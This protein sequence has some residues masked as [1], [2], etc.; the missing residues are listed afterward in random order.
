MK[1]TNNESSELTP[2]TGISVQRNVIMGLGAWPLLMIVMPLLAIP[3]ITLNAI[4]IVTA[5]V[6]AAVAEI[7]VLILA[8]TVTNKTK[9]WKNALYLRN[10]KWKNVALGFLAG[11]T[12]FIVL[13]TA[14]IVIALFGEKV[15]SSDTSTA[16]GQVTGLSK[17]VVL[18]L[19]TP[20]IVPFI[21]ELFFRGVIF[22]FIKDSGIQNSKRA[23]ILGT[24]AS[25]VTFGLAHFQ[26]FDSF[27]GIFV[28]LFIATIG[29]INCWLVYKT[30]SIYT[31]YACH[32]GYNLATS[33]VTF[34]SISAQ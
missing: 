32:M 18:L 22:G 21:E 1:L 3:F 28:V 29:A 24:L 17:Y 11:V 7:L 6:I 15:G 34:I 12:L 9:Q 30:D 25:S 26:G 13:Q 23:L 2:T 5:V 33:I 20:F 8:L 19:I 16:L 14:A 10:F 31:A 27:T 4:N